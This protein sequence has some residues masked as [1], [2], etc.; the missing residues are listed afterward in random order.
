MTAAAT[1]NLASPPPSTFSPDSY[2]KR[3]AL[4]D[5]WDG[6]RRIDIWWTLAWFDIRL[7]YRRS[8]LGPLWLTLSM[9]AMIIGMGPLYSSL[10]NN[11]LTTFFPY[12][13]LGI[14]YWSLFSTIVTDSCT[15]FVNSSSY[16]KQAYFP[17]S[18]FVWRSMSRNLIVFA[19]QIV[20]FLPVAWWVNLE[21]TSNAWLVVPALVITLINAHAIGIMLGLLCTRFRDVTQIVTSVMQVLMFLTPV[22][23]MAS[24]LPT[25]AKFM[26]WNPLAQLL[27]LL[28]TPLMGG[29]PAPEAWL[30]IGGWTIFN[31][32]VASWLF[33]KY[34]RRVIYWL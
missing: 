9:G 13:A 6:T 30:I 24:S 20:L 12:L 28:R 4:A 8:M 16:L 3:S 25:R 32:I 2:P 33:T 5:W 23:W 11:D 17:I 26:L 31:I 22:F 15:T 21:F 27:D 10:F 19:H 29:T 18:L 7:R 14:I 34:R 1:Q